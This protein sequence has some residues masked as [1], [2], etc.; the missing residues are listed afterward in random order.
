VYGSTG[1][2]RSPS[3]DVRLDEV[4]RAA[5]YR[6]V[7]AVTATDEIEAAFRAALISAGPHFVLIKTTTETTAVPR[8]PHTPPSIRDRFRASL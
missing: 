7:A 1:D 6:T 8:I 4:A 2:Q 5:G 3:R